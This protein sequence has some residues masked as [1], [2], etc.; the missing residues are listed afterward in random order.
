MDRA[1]QGVGGHNVLC[2]WPMTKEIQNRGR[3]LLVGLLCFLA[4][5]LWVKLSPERNGSPLKWDGFG[6]WLYLPLTV[7]HDD[8]GMRD[9]SIVKGIMA[10]Y[11]PSGTFYQAHIAPTGNM[12]IRYTPG[13]AIIHLP[14]FLVAHALAERFGYEADGFSLPYQYA[15]VVTYILVVFG[16][17]IFLW[18]VLTAL[19]IWRTAVWALLLTL[20]GTNLFLYFETNPMMT[21]GYSFA[22]YGM[23]LWYTI[24]WHRSPTYWAGLGLGLSLGFAALIRPTDILLVIL[25][26]LWPLEGRSFWAK[27]QHVFRERLLHVGVVG[28][29]SA[30]VVSIL[31]IYWKVY[32]GTW[33]WDSYQNPGEGLDIFH[34][35]LF[36]FLFSF[37]KGWILYS[38]MIAIAMLGLIPLWTRNRGLAIAIL[39]FGTVFTYVVSSWTAWWYP[40]GFGQRAMIQAYP[41]IAILI[42]F[43]VDFVLGG[44]RTIRRIAFSLVT[45]LVALNLFQNHQFRRGVWHISR[46]TRA[47]YTAAFFDGEH[48]A[49]KDALLLLERPTGSEHRFEHRERYERL[50]L[51]GRS[52]DLSGEVEGPGGRRAFKLDAEHEF[53]PALERSFEQLSPGDHAWVRV[54]AFVWCDS[55]LSASNCV[56]VATFDHAGNY[57]YQAMELA[58]LSGFNGGQWNEVEFYY[59]TPEPRHPSDKLRIYGWYRGGPMMWMDSLSMES[60][61]PKGK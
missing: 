22:F 6:Y 43:G 52:M 53:T 5:W 27:A 10:K 44:H 25:P 46:E 55:M 58:T 15:G 29:S 12:V 41:V 49:T 13:L 1:V 59:L 16:G 31:L 19:F 34:P 9:P 39:V 47:H 51:D 61:V 32:A 35:H 60:W 14:G 50:E 38:P 8:L 4:I 24:A 56:L 21:H 7:V 45:L 3:A 28:V 54:S 37:R 11:E 57:G 18:R 40:G 17:L 23:V 33:F 20:F 26:I 2:W 30:A 42:G 48:D 36:D